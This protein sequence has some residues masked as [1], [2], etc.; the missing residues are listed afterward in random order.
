MSQLPA[1]KVEH[2]KLDTQEID[3]R[4]WKWD[5]INIDF[6]TRLPRTLRHHDSI[7]V[8]VDKVIKSLHF[9]A[10]KTTN[11]VDITLMI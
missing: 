8:I 3:I 10:V 7:W 9:L 2:P 4:T 11:S 1:T 6:I 5:V